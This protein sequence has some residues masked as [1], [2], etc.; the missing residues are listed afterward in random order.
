[1]SSIGFAL[2]HLNK[3]V[4]WSTPELPR[5]ENLTRENDQIEI[6][7]EKRHKPK[8]FLFYMSIILVLDS[9]GMEF[10]LRSPSARGADKHTTAHKA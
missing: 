4:I 1:M 9:S 10:A 8:L 6:F 2:F 3:W 7:Q 5:E